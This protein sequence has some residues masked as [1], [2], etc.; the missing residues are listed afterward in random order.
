MSL[1]PFGK[2]STYGRIAEIIS[3]YG[4]ARQVGWALRRL[5][6][7][8][9]VPW[10]RIV[11]SKGYISKSESREGSD[12]IQKELLLAEGIHVSSDFR[13]PLKAHIWCP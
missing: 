13:V 2:L 10:H 4:R 9:N 6:L 11:K 1:V 12:W 5:P 7:P 3:A 8:I